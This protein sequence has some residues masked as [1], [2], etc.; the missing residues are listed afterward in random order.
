MSSKI[1][2]LQTTHYTLL[3]QQGF[4]L[5]EVI[6]ASTVFAL[7]V[8]ALVGAYLYGQEATALAGNRAR[9]VM[10]AEE[11]LEAVRNIRDENFTNLSNG[12]KG[13]VISSNQWAFS[14][15][16]DVTDIFTRRVVIESVEV[17]GEAER[18]KKSITATVTWQ[19]NPQR[20]GTVFLVSRLT[21]WLATNMASILSVNTSGAVIDGADNTKVIG[22]TIQN[23]GAIPIVVDTIKT[24]WS[25]AP[26]GT[27]IEAIRIGGADVWSGSDV[28]NKTQDI[29]NVTLAVGASPTAINF[30]DFSNNMT[31]TTLTLTF[32]MSDGTSS[33]TPVFNP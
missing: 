19:Q 23:I 31:G 5:V 16:S 30:F 20:T 13:L 11:G 33:T 26:G 7:L 1:K 21:N 14:G 10:L 27:K 25:G 24:E 15:A 3:T 12:S 18:N 28:S 22:I 17:A 9:A 4:S 6:L 8:T 29:T 32:T 2:K